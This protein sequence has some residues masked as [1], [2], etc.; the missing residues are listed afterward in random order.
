MFVPVGDLEEK[1]FGFAVPLAFDKQP[2]QFKFGGDI[3]WIE[4]NCRPQS[5]N[6]PAPPE[7]SA[8]A[9]EDAD[10]TAVQE[11][12]NHEQNNQG[13]KRIAHQTVKQ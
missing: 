5:G 8:D 12:Q 11:I 6:L 13:K 9:G 7:R 2:G 10:V 3:V 1:I 4:R